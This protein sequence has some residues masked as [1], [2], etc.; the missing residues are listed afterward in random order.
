M[1][2]IASIR[3]G[4]SSGHST[5]S[6]A[7]TSNVLYASIGSSCNAC[8]ETDPTRASIQQMA[9]DGSNMEPKAVRI[10]NAIGL[11]INPN[12]GT[13]WA[14]DAGQ[15]G[16]PPGHPY[17][18]VDPVTTHPGVAD[19]GWPS[20]EENHQNYGSGANCSSQVIPV[21][22]F[23]AYETIIGIA[24]APSSPHGSYAL[25]SHYG[26]RAFV[27]MHGSWHTQG[28]IPIAP[29]RVSFVPLN[30]DTPASPVNWANPTTQWTDVLIGFQN[31]DGSRNGRPTGVAIGPQGDLFVA[32]DLAGVI[33]R[34]RI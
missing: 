6:V 27:A 15:D 18:F 9:L 22:E 10:R 8:T 30:G 14:G 2:K 33:Y 13:L 24:I 20:C 26:G 12:T 34:V 29:P 32:D 1:S 7:A 21:V 17:E 25:P 28:G 16:L 5:T 31:A 11:T 4:G 3:P 23:P 19:Y